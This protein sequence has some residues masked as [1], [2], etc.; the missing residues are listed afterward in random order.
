MSLFD[1]D[2]V[3]KE[4]TENHILSHAE[5]IFTTVAGRTEDVRFEIN[6]G[7]GNTSHVERETIKKPKVKI[8]Y[9]IDKLFNK[10]NK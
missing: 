6:R 2:L 10:R 9:L 8:Q 1:K 4:V 3:E 7:Y 5:G